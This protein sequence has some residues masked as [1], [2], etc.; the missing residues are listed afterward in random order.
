MGAM[1]SDVIFAFE[2]WDVADLSLGLWMRF[3]GACPFN[4]I[5]KAELE[6][7]LAMDR[8]TA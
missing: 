8:A 4:S 5:S 2:C 7:C 1:G 3:Q 6:G